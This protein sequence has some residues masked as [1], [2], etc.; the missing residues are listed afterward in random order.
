LA[1]VSST[2]KSISNLGIIFAL[3]IKNKTTATN[4]NP[5]KIIERNITAFLPKTSSTTNA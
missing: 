2:P 4:V 5:I 3:M 1:N